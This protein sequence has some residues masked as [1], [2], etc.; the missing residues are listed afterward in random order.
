[1]QIMEQ[2]IENKFDLI[3][4]Y[5]TIDREIFDKEIKTKAFDVLKQDCDSKVYAEGLLA[6]T[7]VCVNNCHYCGL[8][9][10]NG[11]IKRFTLS[12]DNVKSSIKMVKDFGLKSILLIGGENPKI[13]IDDYLRYIEEAKKQDIKV[14]LAMGVFTNNEY[15]QLKDAG[16]DFYTLKFEVSNPDVFNQCNPDI[17]FEERLRAIYG[18]KEAGL[19]LGTG[20]IVGLKNQSLD[21]IVRDIILT[22][23]LEADWVPIV[24]YVPA[25]N[26]IMGKDTPF[27]NVDLLLRSISL[28]RLLLPKAQITAGQPTQDSKLGFSDPVGNIHAMEHGANKLFVEVTPFALRNDFEIIEGRKLL[29]LEKI[30]NMIDGLGLK[31]E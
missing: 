5:L 20:S 26:S 27:G 22:K 15:K 31:R 8:N 13:S 18:V 14:N 3:K 9:R 4:H 16:L 29:Q 7:N 25:K 28:L 12:D 2:Y 23:E 19:K 1:M 24:P 21:D 6:L 17:V 11:E 30:D 10:E